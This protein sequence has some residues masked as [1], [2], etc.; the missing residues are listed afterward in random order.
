[1]SWQSLKKRD[2]TMNEKSRLNFMAL[3]CCCFMVLGFS[4]RLYATGVTAVLAN[5]KQ[6]TL[7]MLDL[8]SKEI[9]NE[10]SLLKEELISNQACAVERLRTITSLILLARASLLEREAILH[11]LKENKMM[12]E[13]KTL[14]EKGVEK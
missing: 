4:P 11:S 12:L 2:K 13:T 9:D 7:N 10:I 5:E 3:L 14:K 8:K 6:A 1:M